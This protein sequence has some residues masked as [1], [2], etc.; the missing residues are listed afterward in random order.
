MPR[1]PPARKWNA[2]ARGEEQERDANAA[3]AAAAD[4]DIGGVRALIGHPLFN[5][6]LFVSSS[7]TLEL[8]FDEIDF[9]VLLTLLGKKFKLREKH[10]WPLRRQ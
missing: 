3:A 7:T 8:D 10:R 4:L 2:A 1:T 9:L 6:M 5:N